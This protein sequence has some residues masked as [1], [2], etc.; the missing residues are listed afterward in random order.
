MNPNKYRFIVRCSLMI[1]CI[2]TYTEDQIKAQNEASAR[3][4]VIKGRV[5]REDGKPLA[6]ERIFLV[7]CSSKKK[8]DVILADDMEG[9]STAAG[10][11]FG[12]TDEE[13][14]FEIKFDP[15]F[16]AEKAGDCRFL[17]LGVINDKELV[18]LK[19]DEL[20][21]LFFPDQLDTG[22][23]LDFGELVIV[24]QFYHR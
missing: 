1:L 13:G 17:S 7:C 8:C 24:L 10:S 21:V 20:A 11:P 18:K 2:I 15:D 22:T 3:E 5:L 12:Y 23:E 4:Y 19:K 9:D 14:V 16:I 6:N